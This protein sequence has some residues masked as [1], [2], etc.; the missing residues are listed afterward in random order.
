MSPEV[1]GPLALLLTLCLKRS[2]CYNTVPFLGL[3]PVPSLV[4]NFLERMSVTRTLVTINFT[5]DKHFHN[6]KG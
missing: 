6:V 1:S 2:F 5:I 4:R 3:S